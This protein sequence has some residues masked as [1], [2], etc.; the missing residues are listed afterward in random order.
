LAVAALVAL[1]GS[2]IAMDRVEPAPAAPMPRVEPAGPELPAAPPA[3]PGGPAIAPPAPAGESVIKVRAALLRGPGTARLTLT[4]TPAPAATP[5]EAGNY[6]GTFRST[7]RATYSYYDAGAKARPAA[8]H[9]TLTLGFDGEKTTHHTVA[10]LTTVVGPSEA[11]IRRVFTDQQQ[12]AA[13]LLQPTIEGGLRAWPAGHTELLWPEDRPQYYLEQV[14]PD[15]YRRIELADKEGYVVEVRPK[16]TLPQLSVEVE[17]AKNTLTGGKYDDTIRAYVGQPTLVQTIVTPTVTLTP[18]QRV[19]L[20]WQPQANLAAAAQAP[21]AWKKHV[22]APDTMLRREAE[23]QIHAELKQTEKEYAQAMQRY[24]AGHPK[25]V[26]SQRRI[27]DLLQ[28]LA[29]AQG[30]HDFAMAYQPAAP[31]WAVGTWEVRLAAEP[32]EV[33][34]VDVKADGDTIVRLPEE[35][36]TLAAMGV[37][38]KKPIDAAGKIEFELTVDGETARLSGVVKPDGTGSGTLHADDE[39]TAWTARRLGGLAQ[40]GLEAAQRPMPA[41]MVGRWDVTVM[42]RGDA[43]DL[44][45]VEARANGELVVHIP[46]DGGV[47]VGAVGLNGKTPLD[48]SGK[49]ECDVTYEGEIVRITGAVRPDGTGSGTMGVDDR[50]VTWTARR[51]GAGEAT[52]AAMRAEAMTRLRKELDARLEAEAVAAKA[53]AVLRQSYGAAKAEAGPRP[54]R[55]PAETLEQAK[56]RIEKDLATLQDQLLTQPPE[57]REMPR[58]QRQIQQLERQL[59][60]LQAGVAPPWAVGGWKLSVPEE[61]RERLIVL[62]HQGEVAPLTPDFIV[63]GEARDRVIDPT[64]AVELEV[65]FTGDAGAFAGRINPDGTARGA[66]KLGNGKTAAWTATR[67]GGRVDT[68]GAVAG[69]PATALPAIEAPAATIIRVAAPPWAVGEWEVTPKIEEYPV[70]ERL[71]VVVAG[72]GGVTVRPLGEGFPEVTVVELARKRPVQPSGNV[73]FGMQFVSEVGDEAAI[74]IDGKLTPGG[75]GRGTFR[76]GDADMGTWTATRVRRGGAV[77]ALDTD[78]QL[79]EIRKTT[80]DAFGMVAEPDALGFAGT[81]EVPNQAGAFGYGNPQPYITPQG[82]S[83]LFLRTLPNNTVEGQALIEYEN[84]VAQTAPTGVAVLIELVEAAEDAAAP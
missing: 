20:V 35:Q 80:P 43:D 59:S 79:E 33:V 75:T 42:D 54:A 25:L 36:G 58:I 37:G 65:Q 78:L 16:G 55:A 84:A 31:P 50:M 83:L 74:A 5:G 52:G 14:E 21:V 17:L 76:V 57:G 49:I 46:E 27:A 72:D 29:A 56:T 40:T 22:Q 1:P 23:A 11:T 64:G 7:A 73:A 28:R 6:Y 30:G 70:P 3:L 24:A 38:G 45:A 71:S 12:A 66:V 60:Q 32:D 53:R 77:G 48:A 8:G 44:F 39:V 61:K 62:T 69:E 81:A 26:E 9:A 68:A 15:L 63:T 18:G 4:P 10:G 34:V 82:E 41:W 2:A 67:I 19:L 47:Q 51:V 13:V